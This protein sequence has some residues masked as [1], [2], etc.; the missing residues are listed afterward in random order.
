MIIKKIYCVVLMSFMLLQTKSQVIWTQFEGPYSGNVITYTNVGDT[1]FCGTNQSGVYSSTDKG[2]NWGKILEPKVGTL[3][4]LKYYKSHLF[5]SWNHGSYISE[6]TGRSW[7]ECITLPGTNKF[8]EFNKNLYAATLKGVFVF[9]TISDNWI[10]KNSGLPTGICVNN[11]TSI[12]SKLFTATYNGFLYFSDDSGENWQQLPPPYGSDPYQIYVLSSH[13]GTLYIFNDLDS[14]LYSSADFGTS[15][16]P[17]CFIKP[18]PIIGGIND[19]TWYNGSAYMP[20]TSGVYKYSPKDSTIKC[21]SGKYFVSSYAKDSNLFVSSDNGLYRLDIQKDTFLLSNKG[22]NSSIVNDLHIF[23]ESIFSATNQGTYYTSNN[24]GDWSIVDST[25][26]IRCQSIAANDSSIYIGTT[27][28][29]FTSKDLKNWDH[30]DG[31]IATP[32][33][34]DIQ[35]DKD[36]NTMYAGIGAGGLYKSI[37]WGQNWNLIPSKVTDIYKIAIGNNTLLATSNTGLYA[38]TEGSDSLNLIGFKDDHITALKVIDSTVYVSVLWNDNGIYKSVDSC[39]SW[40]KISG[41]IINDICKR[42]DRNLYAGSWGAMLYSNNNGNSM[43]NWSEVGIPVGYVNCILQSDTAF[44]AGTYGNSIYKRSYLNLTDCSSQKY[45]IND[46]SISGIPSN[47]PFDSL[48]QNID[49]A[50]GSTLTIVQDS[51]N[52]SNFSSSKKNFINNDSKIKIIA[53]DGI[54]SKVLIIDYFTVIEKPEIPKNCDFVFPNP[55][56]NILNIKPLYSLNSKV[57]IYDMN[58]KKILSGHSLNNRFDISCL[59]KGLYIIKLLN[60]KFIM[61]N[62]FVKE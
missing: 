37:D 52:K 59:N 11:I 14:K 20:S 9:D 56:T 8:F 17:V 10:D 5:A 6:D 19:I 4:A 31:G 30:A 44:Y 41:F 42:G 54:T 33:V 58:G 49:L 22:I 38:L 57:E 34:M 1:L 28:G 45:T 18:M 61:I 40:T 16:N 26:N 29:I 47:T 43:D 25:K 3:M 51:R 50:H 32:Y 53:E 55:A 60:E 24:G 35:I 48:L 62:K 7:V 23:K 15:W 36:K 12:G 2:Y 27:N 13:S 21:Y 46:T 39:K